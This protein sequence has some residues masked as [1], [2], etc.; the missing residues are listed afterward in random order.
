MSQTTTQM[1]VAPGALD[2]FGRIGRTRREDNMPWSELL[3]W[4]GGGLVAVGY[5]VATVISSDKAWFQEVLAARLALVLIAIAVLLWRV[6]GRQL[7]RQAPV[8]FL[9]AFQ[10]VHA[11]SLY[12]AGASAGVGTGSLAMDFAGLIF[13]ALSVVFRGS[14]PAWW[15]LFV[16]VATIGILGPLVQLTVVERLSIGAFLKEALLPVLSLCVGSVIVVARDTRSLSHVARVELDRLTARNLRLVNDLRTMENDMRSLVSL[17][18]SSTDEFREQE[19]KLEHEH[20]YEH[21]HERERVYEH[22]YAYDYHEYHESIVGATGEVGTAGSGASLNPMNVYAALKEAVEET[23]A[24]LHDERRQ[25]KTRFIVAGPAEVSIPMAVRGEEA[26]LRLIFRSL[27]AQAVKAI[28][29]G[30]GLLRLQMRIGI[31][32][33]V[34]TIEDNG[35]G[36]S[37]EMLA[38]IGAKEGLVNDLSMAEVRELCRSFGGTIGMHARLGVGARVTLELPRVD[39]FAQGI[40]SRQATTMTRTAVVARP[41]VGGHRDRDLMTSTA[42]PSSA[43]V[44]M[45]SGSDLR[46][47]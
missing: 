42:V 40:G 1:Q 47:A 8:F 38:K 16:P 2:G 43:A 46:H 9:V 17:V 36:L 29:S 7:S 18:G 23:R 15:S 28:G 31:G 6:S 30:E 25:M 19:H 37:E 20:E 5:S 35:R 14:L 11:L 13:L 41:V 39:A 10:C 24:Y 21:A 3:F 4:G 33:A 22:E 12:H 27:L 32:S 44:S 45:S 26:A 34:I